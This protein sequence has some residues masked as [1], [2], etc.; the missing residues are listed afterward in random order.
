MKCRM[1]ACRVFMNSMKSFLSW[2]MMWFTSYMMCLFIEVCIFCTYIQMWS[3]TLDN[4]QLH[5][6]TAELLYSSKN[7]IFTTFIPPNPLD[8]SLQEE[9]N[10]QIHAFLHVFHC[11][12]T[13][14]KKKKKTKTTTKTPASQKLRFLS[15][16]ST[17]GSPN[18]KAT[19]RSAG[20]GGEEAAGSGGKMVPVLRYSRSFCFFV[21]FVC[22]VFFIIFFWF[23]LFFFFW[24]FFFF[25]GGGVFWCFL[26]VCFCFFKDSFG[27]CCCF[28][29][30]CF[31]C[32]LVFICVFL[33]LCCCW[34]RFCWWFC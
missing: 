4:L 5:G 30:V 6:T 25:W 7:L 21:F 2:L 15:L 29:Y 1:C 12:N 23:L 34:F 13:Q 32:F 11:L 24:C 27:L 17:P 14:K 9:R 8:P 18:R 33:W 3:V 19:P 20:G 31:V 10:Y 26:V 22:V 28:W 16:I